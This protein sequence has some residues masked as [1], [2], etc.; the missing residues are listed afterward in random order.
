MLRQQTA[1]LRRVP[2]RRRLGA[3]YAPRGLSVAVIGPDGAGKSTLIRSLHALPDLPTEMIYMGGN[4]A[5]ANHSL[6]TARWLVRH[7]RT[8]DR[9]ARRLPPP[10][11]PVG[12]ALRGPRLVAG[13]VHD[14]LEYAYRFGVAAVARRRGAVVLFDRYVYDAQIDAIVDGASA[15]QRLRAALFRRLFPTP[16]LVLILEAPGSLLFARKGE[17]T[18][19]RLERVGRACREVVRGLPQ[20]YLDARLPPPE[21]LRAAVAG[22]QRH[23]ARPQDADAHP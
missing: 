16:D 5:S 3:A 4:R 13:L 1:G 23:R 20:E 21:V 18:P 12:R 15:W 10:G 7:G 19:E 14:V 11:S 8:I 9:L 2:R 6:P 17:H 22:I